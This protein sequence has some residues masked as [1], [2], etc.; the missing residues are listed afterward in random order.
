V[1]NAGR[2]TEWALR[3]YIGNLPAGRQR[4][5]FEK[6]LEKLDEPKR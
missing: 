5:A 2:E 4:D 6:A 3:E 1:T